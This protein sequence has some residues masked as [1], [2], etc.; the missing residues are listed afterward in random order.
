M[1]RRE[2]RAGDSHMHRQIAD[3]GVDGPCADLDAGGPHGLAARDTRV[4]VGPVNRGRVEREEV[5]DRVPRIARVRVQIP[6]IGAQSLMQRGRALS[7]PFRI[8]Q[9]LSS[10]I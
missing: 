9:D 3:A 2:R 1:E 5:R 7:R 4:V 6:V 8:W 10:P